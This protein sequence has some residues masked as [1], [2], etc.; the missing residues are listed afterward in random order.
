[1][2][3]AGPEQ[4]RIEH[5]KTRRIR[6]RIPWCAQWLHGLVFGLTVNVSLFGGAPLQPI[7]LRCEYLENPL[8]LD[9][10]H[11]RLTW[12][13][14]SKERGQKQT[15]Y[16]ILVA[17]DQDLLRRNQGDV[18]DSGQVASG[19]TVNVVYAGKE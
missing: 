10:A 1:M 6:P 17:S 13:G 3:I 11:P 7:S 18:W 15:A 8:G 14:E 19:E 9:E 2:R 12:R 16:Q 5:S 4:A